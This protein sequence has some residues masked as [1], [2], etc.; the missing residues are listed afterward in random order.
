MSSQPVRYLV[1]W[2][3]TRCNLHCT[4]CYRR[5]EAA[6]RMRR[7]VARAALELA[8]ASGAPFHVQMAGGEPTL[9]PDLIEYTG[10]LIRQKNWPATI[11]IQTN[12]T[13]VDPALIATCV[14]YQIDVGVS[15]DGPP[16]VQQNVRGKARETYRGLAR[17]NASAVPTRVTAV[18]CSQTI[19]SVSALVMCLSSFSNIRGFGFDP[20]V[21]KG[22]A[23]GRPGLFADPAEARHAAQAICELL[24][25]LNRR[26]PRPLV[27]REFEA[28]HSALASGKCRTHYCHAARGESMAVDPSG[29]VYP[30]SQVVG[31]PHFAAG[32]VDAVDWDVLSR[33]FRGVL[34]PC[35]DSSCGLYGRCPGDCPS[36]VHFENHSTA[37]VMCGLYRGVADYLAKEGL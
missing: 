37:S 10:A 2:L 13:L 17:L 14:R 21:A 8:A 26:R 1:L 29:A 11:A 35:A 24:R 18:L 36:R 32:T 16:E 7:E 5:P 20:L 15:V 12:A 23:A 34:L 25:D 6:C 28:V 4:Y 9:E 27:W 19:A 22:A 31:E 30:C 3:T 33:A